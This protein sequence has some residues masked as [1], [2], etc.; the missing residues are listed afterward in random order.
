MTKSL[1][2][3]ELTA[4]LQAGSSSLIADLLAQADRTAA[5]AKKGSNVEARK[6]AHRKNLAENNKLALAAVNAAFQKLIPLGQTIAAYS[7]Q[8]MA[9]GAD[10]DQIV[11][12]M[13]AYT[14][15][16]LVAEAQSAIQDLVKTLVFRSMDKAFADEEFPEHTNGFID[17]PATG[18]RFAREGAGRKPAEID[19]DALAELVGPEVFAQ[20]TTEVVTRKIDESALS[21]AV[22]ADP[23]LLESVRAAIVPGDWKSPRLMV[24]DIPANDKE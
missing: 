7:E 16:K 6:A 15:G 23:A 2:P 8:V 11:D 12:L 5:L 9:D 1:A 3:A 21:A 13:T 14:E 22:L 17:V 18:K 19:L 20:V 4:L 10:E 24:R